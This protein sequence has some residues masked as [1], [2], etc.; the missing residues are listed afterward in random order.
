MEDLLIKFGVKREE[1]NAQELETLER[2]AQSLSQSQV[3]IP[4]L[5]NYLNEMI[6]ALERELTGHDYPKGFVELF[7]RKKRLRHLKARLHN[8]ILLRDFL[9][10]PE[11]ARSYVEKHLSNLKKI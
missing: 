5:K 4:D 6:T 3:T 8:Y 10:A 7:F 9:V 2:W 1:M 11:K